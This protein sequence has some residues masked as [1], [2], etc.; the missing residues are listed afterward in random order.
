MAITRRRPAPAAPPCECD[1]LRPVVTVLAR[2]VCRLIV[3]ASPGQ[4]PA[5]LR[6]VAVHQ[7]G[8]ASDAEIDVIEKHL[9]GHGGT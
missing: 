5:T 3:H 2:M 8:F 1:E 7:A 4:H 9:T 6:Q